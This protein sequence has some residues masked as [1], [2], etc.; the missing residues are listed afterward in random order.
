MNFF[1]NI[2]PYSLGRHRIFENSSLN[3]IVPPV[4]TPSRFSCVSVGRY[5]DARIRY[6]LTSP[7]TYL[8]ADPIKNSVKLRQGCRSSN[9]GGN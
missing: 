5:P 8:G 2:I 1:T 9:Q 4:L 6:F 7:Q 3:N